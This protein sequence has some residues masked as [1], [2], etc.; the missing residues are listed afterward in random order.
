MELAKPMKD[1]ESTNHQ[2]RSVTD[3][4][5]YSVAINQF[6]L[7]AERLGIDPG[8][9]KV[10]SHSKRE[11][12]VHFPVK[13]DSGDVEIF[14]G[15]RI[16]HNL[17]RGPGKGGI[18]YHPNLTLNHT[19]A[20]AMWMTW[21]CAVT[22]IPYGGAKGGVIC[23][24]KQLSLTELERLT[25]RYASEI[26]IVI[27][28][29]KDI[30]APDV[31][32]DAQIM[33]WI[34]DTFSMHLGYTVTGVVTGKP[35]E[36][37]GTLGRVDATGRGVM[38]V[39][40]EAAAKAGIP[41]QGA[42]IAVQ[43]FGNVGY[44]AAQLLE[45]QGCTIIGVADSEGGVYKEKGIDTEG[46]KAHQNNYGKLTGYKDADTISPSDILEV[47]C[48]ILIPA[49][50]EGQIDSTNASKVQARLVVEG[51]NG[52]TD[53]AADDILAERGITVIPDILANAGGVIVSYFEWVQDNQAY[54]WDI[55]E[56]NAKMEAVMI[57]SF[58][59]VS[60]VSEKRSVS[61]RDAAM[62]VAVERVSETMKRRGLYP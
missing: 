12:I 59:N 50:I 21:K 60:Q 49:A 35:L 28:P 6:E 55:D 54:F 34:M 33:S 57:K 19:R 22:G 45:Q 16:Q 46:L 27:G 15:F 14:T 4:G 24:P 29:G 23:D 58:N 7:A 52:P 5:V 53:Q 20:L 36:I 61:M 17:A 42:K 32:T 13:M 31:N 43:G 48:D 38:I 9:R 41:L 26:S 39:T 44:F 25:R 56:I 2:N 37:C 30:P 3:D 51:A 10:L 11:L 8:T 62:L 40:R 18:R 47:P 1:F